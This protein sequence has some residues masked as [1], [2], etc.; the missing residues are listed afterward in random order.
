MLEEYVLLKGKIVRGF[1]SMLARNECNL[2]DVCRLIM[3]RNKL[4]TKK[5]KRGKCEYQLTKSREKREKLCWKQFFFLV[6]LYLW[7]R[8]W[9]GR[10]KK[11]PALG[12]R[13]K[14]LG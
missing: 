5:R 4:K 9:E 10:K 14:K 8:K 1:V 13:K 6:N 2:Y 11:F 12:E 7:T 3:L